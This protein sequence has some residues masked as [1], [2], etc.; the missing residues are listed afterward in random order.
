M[1]VTPSQLGLISKVLDA[2]ALRQRVIG[3]NVANVNTPGYER[4]EVVFEEQ[5]NQLLETERPENG[6]L[7]PT[8]LKT[9]GLT[10][11]S[12]GNN[13]D[14][15]IEMGQLTKNGALFETYTQILAAQLGT[16]RSAITGR[17]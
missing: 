16:L 15:D 6:A 3:Q 1:S 2:T 7:Q 10:K 13:V 9:E 8:V 17:S 5:L 11:R 14:I 12:D 4:S